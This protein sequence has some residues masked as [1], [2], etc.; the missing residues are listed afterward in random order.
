MKTAVLDDIES[1]ALRESP[2]HALNARAKLLVAVAFLVTLAS[3]GRTQVSAL[4]PL[5]FLL[6]SWALLGTVSLRWILA[7]IVLPVGFLSVFGLANVVFDRRVE[8]ILLGVPLSAGLLSWFSIV[9]RSIL[10]LAVVLLLVATTGMMPLAG[11]LQRLG[12]PRVLVSTILLLYRYLFVLSDEA[13]RMNRA[14]LA[15]SFGRRG[16]GMSAAAQ[17]LGQLMLRSMARA[18]R[19]HAAMLARGFGGN[20]VS[21]PDS[22][23]RTTDTVF[24]LVSL[25]FLAAVRFWDVTQIVGRAALRVLS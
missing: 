15:R 25:L 21:G 12:V 13:A 24:V 17:I 23:W 7:R 16:L 9:L 8:L 2:I 22:E 3:F 5:A 20:M 18:E 11:A 14:R 6:V 19:I 10:S 1:L 4:S